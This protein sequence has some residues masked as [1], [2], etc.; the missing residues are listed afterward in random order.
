M[1]YNFI[2]LVLNSYRA[3]KKK[4]CSPLL[5]IEKFILQEMWQNFMEYMS[6]EMLPKKAISEYTKNII[7]IQCKIQWRNWNWWTLCVLLFWR[8]RTVF[9]AYG[10]FA[11]KMLLFFGTI[12]Q[13]MTPKCVKIPLPQFQ[14]KSQPKKLPYRLKCLYHFV[15]GIFCTQSV[16]IF[17]LFRTLNSK[18]TTHKNLTFFLLNLDFLI[19]RISSFIFQW[20]FQ[21]IVSSPSLFNKSNYSKIA[22]IKMESIDEH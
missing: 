10:I 2:Q 3:K 19:T 21:K 12:I 6:L 13:K 17:E 1:H 11:P 20:L 8:R 4:N 22:C 16:P 18:P 15:Y 14:F 9:S 5:N 7:L